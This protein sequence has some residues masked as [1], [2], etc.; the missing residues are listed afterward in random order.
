MLFP[1][2]ENPILYVSN[3]NYFDHYR[4]GIKIFLENKINGV[5]LKNYRIESSN[6]AK[7]TKYNWINSSIHP[8]QVHIEI[9]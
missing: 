9:Q 6:Q 2:I 1:I 8:H 5:G 4:F 7:Y 3:L